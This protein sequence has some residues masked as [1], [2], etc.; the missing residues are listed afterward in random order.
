MLHWDSYGTRASDFHSLMA[1]MALGALLWLGVVA[2][3]AASHLHRLAPLLRRPLTHACVA[4][5]CALLA[6]SG[7]IGLAGWLA[8]LGWPSAEFTVG[9]GCGG[10]GGHGGSGGGGSGGGSGGGLLGCLHSYALLTPLAVLPLTLDAA[11]VLA[12]ALEQSWRDRASD[13]AEER[14]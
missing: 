10:S 13:V 6:S 12:Y 9:G 11:F 1:T 7:G 8:S 2:L 3:V 14:K 4:V 5:L